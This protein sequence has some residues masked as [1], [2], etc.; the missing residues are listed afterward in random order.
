MHSLELL[1]NT[2]ANVNHAGNGQLMV[3]FMEERGEIL[4]VPR[5][6]NI[7]IN[8]SDFFKIVH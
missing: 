4:G 8:S 2:A 7:R 1:Q 5:H 6:D 3:L